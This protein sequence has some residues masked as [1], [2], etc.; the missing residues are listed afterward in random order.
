ME[1]CSEFL[2]IITGVFGVLKSKGVIQRSDAIWV[3]SPNHILRTTQAPSCP[4][5]NGPAV[6][7]MVYIIQAAAHQYSDVN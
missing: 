4:I 5:W 7:P 1:V 2:K 6:E 3:W